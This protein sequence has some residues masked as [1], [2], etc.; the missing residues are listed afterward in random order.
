MSKFTYR[1][2]ENNTVEVFGNDS[3]VV[4]QPTWG[5]G[6]AWSNKEEAEGWAEIF[7]ESLNNPTSEFV[8]GISP[9]NH[10]IVRPIVTEQ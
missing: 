7:T 3:L 2:T 10:P 8:A 6:S 5:D 9:N 4:T 1:V